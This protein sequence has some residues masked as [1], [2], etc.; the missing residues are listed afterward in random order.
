MHL[1]IDSFRV[2]FCCISRLNHF[3]NIQSF[4]TVL[5]GNVDGLKKKEK[6][7]EKKGDATKS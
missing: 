1:L 5:K 3:L 6:K 2:S 4:G 7:K